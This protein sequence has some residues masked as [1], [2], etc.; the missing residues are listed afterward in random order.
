MDYT[1]LSQEEF[2]AVVTGELT[3]RAISIESE[4]ENVIS[5]YFV[6]NHHR[7][8]DFQ[9]L[10]LRRDGLSAQDKIE[11]VRAML[12]LFGLTESQVVE[13]KS[14]LKQAEEFKGWRNATSHGTDV[15]PQPYA[16]E[17]VIE[18]VN[19][20]GVE[21]QVSITPASHAALIERTDSLIDKLAAARVSLFE[22]FLPKV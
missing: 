16:G 22:S 10:L 1:S 4:L 17:L 7:R 8:G 9:R 18:I 21:K 3:H 19:R 11:V 6:E 15:T 2:D 12:P 5:G 13:W 20:A 14:A